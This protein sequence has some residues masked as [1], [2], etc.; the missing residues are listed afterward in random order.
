MIDAFG[1]KY[2]EAAWGVLTFKNGKQRVEVEG[3]SKCYS[4][5]VKLTQ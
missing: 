1:G 2:E 4:C 5:F 3:N